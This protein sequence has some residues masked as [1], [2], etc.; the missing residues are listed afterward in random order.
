M[1][2]GIISDIHGN[3]EALEAAIDALSREKIDRY[4]C[5]GDI[6]GYGADP[7]ECIEKTKSLNPIIVLGNHDAASAGITDTEKFTDAARKA[8]IWTKKNLK[9]SDIAFLKGLSLIYKNE[10]L[11]LAHGTLHEPEKFHYMLDDVTARETFN[12]MTR[13]ICFVGHSHAPGIFSYKG[14]RLDYFY[15]EKTKL[16]RGEL[17]IVNAGS[18]GQPRDGDP[19]LSYSVY[20]TEAL[21]VEL[22]RITYDIPK[23]QKKIVDAGLPAFLAY[24]LGAG[25]EF[26]AKRGSEKENIKIERINK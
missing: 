7:G 17:L 10:D 14:D 8:V 20:D 25:R 9:E 11:V 18:V 24:R 2:Y 23:A 19:R 22:K 12:L 15:K 26:R 4:L 6:V 16:S 3:L 13:A 1:R 21:Q 5:V